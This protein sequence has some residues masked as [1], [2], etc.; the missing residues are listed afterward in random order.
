M[1]LRGP[2]IDEGQQVDIHKP[3]PWHNLR[4]FLKE[5]GIIVLGVL[6]ALGA[7]QAVESLHWRHQVEAGEAALREDIRV[8]I[9]D[10]ATRE[11]LSPCL[12]RRLRAVAAVLDEA[13]AKGRLPAVGQLGTPGVLRWSLQSWDALVAAQTPAHM[14]HD[15]MTFYGG[16][17]ATAQLMKNWNHEEQDAWA[18]L[19]TIVG[20]G[21]TFGDAEQATVRYSLS[22]A[23]LAAKT[24]RQV[25][26]QMRDGIEKAGILS[27]AEISDIRR[28]AAAQ[29][30]KNARDGIMCK[31]LD[32]APAADNYGQAPSPFDLSQPFTP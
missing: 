29:Y 30:A 10:G 26:A 18:G 2:L 32:A 11:A 7:E 22:R 16:E 21:R 19:Y 1:R 15:D 4:E 9:A 25:A 27:P 8:L 31:P 28:T 17:Y 5:Y 3:K 20:P 12:D 6:T 13:A 24:M 14:S 23:V